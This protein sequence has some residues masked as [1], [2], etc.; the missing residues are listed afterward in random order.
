MAQLSN[1]AFYDKW[2]P[3]LA[4]NV[5]QDIDGERFEQLLADVRDTFASQANVAAQPVA[6][7]VNFDPVLRQLTATHLLGVSELEYNHNNGGFTAY[8]SVQ[9][10]DLD[11]GQGE[12]RFRVRA[13]TGRNASQTTDSPQIVVKA[14][15]GASGPLSI[16]ANQISDA[17]AA[18]RGLLRADTTDAQLAM[19]DYLRLADY[20]TLVRVYGESGAIK[21]LL[22]QVKQLAATA[23]PAAPVAPTDPQVEDTA[24]TLSGKLVPGYLAVADY[25]VFGAP[26]FPGIVNAAAAGADVQNGRIISRGLTGSILP[27]SA[28]IR[29]A[30]SGNRPA[31]AWML[32]DRAFTGPVVVPPPTDTVNPYISFVVPAAGATL[33]P[34]TQVMLTV[35]A[36]DNVGVQ[37]VTFANG[38]TGAL[39]GPG[40]KNGNTYTLPYTP[41][42]AGPL[43]LVATATD[44]AGNS[45]SATINMVVGTTTTPTP[46]PDLTAALAISVASLT[47]GT[48]VSFSVTAAKGTAPYA[49]EVVATDTA[50]GQQFTLGT[51]RT[52]SW[53]PTAVGSYALEAF[54]TDSSSPVQAAQSA[55]RYLQV[56][57]AANRIPVADA[58]QDVTVQLPTS[59]VAL[60]GTASDPDSGDTLTYAWRQITGP[61]NAVGLP[62]T[63][64]NVVASGLI[65]GAYQFG[66]RSTDNH[67]AQ[68]QEDYVVVTVNASVGKPQKL[69]FATDSIGSAYLKVT[70]KALARLNASD[71]QTDRI[72]YPGQTTK[73]YLDS[74]MGEI[75]AAYDPAYDCYLAVILFTNDI[76]SYYI[77]VI[78]SQF[79]Q[80]CSQVK[81]MGYKGITWAQAGACTSAYAYARDSNNNIIGGSDTTARQAGYDSTRL[82]LN[83]FLLARKEIELD[84]VA[85][86]SVYPNVYNQAQGYDG[87]YIYQRNQGPFAASPFGEPGGVHPTDD[88]GSTYWAEAMAQAAAA[89]LK[90]SLVPA[91]VTIADAPTA[92][93][94][95]DPTYISSPRV[96]V[97]TSANANAAYRSGVFTKVAGGGAWNTSGI[98]DVAVDFQKYAPGQK[99][100]IEYD[101]PA[102]DSGGIFGLVEKDSYDSAPVDIGQALL[103]WYFDRVDFGP[104]Q[105]GWAKTP[106]TSTRRAGKPR[107]ELLRGTSVDTIKYFIGTEPEFTHSGRITKPICFGTWLGNDATG[108]DGASTTPACTITGERIFFL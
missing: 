27:G 8:A 46:T 50:T 92:P 74:H 87:R 78:K 81:A 60:M 41:A 39:L 11:H 68:S 65:A 107:L 62:A 34:G 84:Q 102:R 105:G 45:E 9:V 66:F 94:N 77:E 18:G 35:T 80:F 70:D 71:L 82:N 108:P 96:P 88:Y 91:T 5:F 25:E 2:V 95:P 48:P 43:S 67:G 101:E 51:A 58:G 37:A 55:I 83:S 44:A 90:R 1:Q 3:L 64:L 38:A 4:D 19:L 7:A 53:T 13:A 72:A 86:L 20:P 42:S 15:T 103:A 28:G 21:Y 32:N 75:A 100:I 6:P 24:D 63:T 59:S 93:I 26:G 49:Y 98:G 99:L 76:N 12:W 56:V 14:S 10:D 89:M 61:N 57:Q 73:D 104:W 30:A 69:V 31:G 33:T 47:L 36:T 22:D 23:A 17:G 52:G 97:Y 106:N 29:V 40:A 16:T 54:V 85:V 79:Q